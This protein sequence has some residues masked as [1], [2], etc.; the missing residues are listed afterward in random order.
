MPSGKL[1][2]P[3]PLQGP[4][5]MIWEQIDFVVSAVPH[6]PSL[7]PFFLREVAIKTLV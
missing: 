3:G 5:K 2:G 6:T 7:S 1:L 4:D